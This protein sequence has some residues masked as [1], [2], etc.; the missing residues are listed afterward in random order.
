M[1][2]SECTWRCW[3]SICAHEGGSVKQSH[4]AAPTVHL[5]FEVRNLLCG[6]IRVYNGGSTLAAPHDAETSKFT[7]PVI[8]HHSCSSSVRHLL[9]SVKEF[10][11]A[12][13]MQLIH[14]INAN[15]LLWPTYCSLKVL[16]HHFVGHVSLAPSSG[17][18]YWGVIFKL[19]HFSRS[20]AIF[21]QLSRPQSG[22]S[23]KNLTSNCIVCLR[24]WDRRVSSALF[25]R[26]WGRFVIFLDIPAESRLWKLPS[27][28]STYHCISLTY[29][30]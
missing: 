20:N 3:H 14:F 23:L 24:L 12:I 19:V 2:E 25:L 1:V 22:V 28:G 8:R 11:E 18:K 5:C 17:L 27:T 30:L 16:L 29:V 6:S 4:A 10:I 21:W 26:R 7:R 9:Q 13:I 15:V